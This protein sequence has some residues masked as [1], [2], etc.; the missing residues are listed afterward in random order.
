MLRESRVLREMAAGVA[1]EKMRREGVMVAK[2]YEE[3]GGGETHE[4]H[5][6]YSE[7]ESRHQA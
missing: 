2:K 1:D 6:S 3:G 7:N 5:L 4:H